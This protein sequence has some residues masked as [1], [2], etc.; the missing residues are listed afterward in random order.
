MLSC[1]E[2]RTRVALEPSTA[3]PE[4]QT[5]L[6]D[7]PIC[8]RYQ[9]NHQTLD[10]V[11]QV[12]MQWQAPSSLTM[13]LLA[14]ATAGPLALAAPPVRP[15]RWYVNLV[16]TLTFLLV[17]ISLMIAWQVLT[18]LATQ[19]GL[20]ETFTWLMSLPGG[21]MQDLTRQLPQARYAVELFGQ[22]RDQ[23]LWLLAM[24]MLW[25]ASERRAAPQAA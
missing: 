19:F 3:D 12:N 10:A 14:L 11:L 1:E 7:C 13:Q 8:S 2:V 21:W 6:A 5:H 25:A 15:K 18:V 17:V 24:L 9:R 20:M 23:L 4:V 16:Y 22:V